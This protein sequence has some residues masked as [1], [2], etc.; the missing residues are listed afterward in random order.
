VNGVNVDQFVAANE[1][2]WQ[3]LATLTKEANSSIKSL[4]PA[5]LQELIALYQRT[6]AH[7]SYARQ[8]YR[9]PGLI[10]RLTR[11]VANANGVIYGKRARTVRSVGRF[12]RETFPAAVWHNRR[13]VLVSAALFFVPAIAMGAWLGTSDEAVEVSA[14]EAVREAYLEEDFEE[15]YSS[16]P[17]AQFATQVTINNIQ[18]AILAF[19]LGIFLCVGTAYVLVNNGVGVGVAGGL[20]VHA[21]QASKFFGLILPHGLLELSAIV[22]AGAAGLRLGWCIIDPGDRTRSEALAE[23]GRRS[24][25]IVMGLVFAFICAGM[26]EGFVTGT[27]LPTSIRVGIGVLAYT[28]FTLWIVV[29]G[30][31]ATARGITGLLG[32]GEHVTWETLAPPD[33]KPE[34]VVTPDLV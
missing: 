31:Q 30:R 8:A 2:A 21:G 3:R 15:Y 11:L 5:Q 25:V 4:S 17:A 27:G 29:Y 19:A 6:S 34:M 10:S 16:E 13:F 1:G 32:E 28:I 18:V 33:A 23:E 20:F 12:F 9:D 26:I 24:V 14:P 22:V 7:L